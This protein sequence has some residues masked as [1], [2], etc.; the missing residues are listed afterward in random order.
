MLEITLPPLLPGRSATV[1]LP[2][3]WSVAGRLHGLGITARDR[4]R[5]DAT[6]V[7]PRELNI[8]REEVSQ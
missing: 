2:L 8:A 4:S 1:P 5:D 6:V 3:R 7:P